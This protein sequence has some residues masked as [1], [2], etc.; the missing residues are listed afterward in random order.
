MGVYNDG[1]EL[2][3]PV[4]PIIPILLLNERR[5]SLECGQGGVL[6]YKVDPSSF[7]SNIKALK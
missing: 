1:G 2:W 7:P 3:A 4:E 6:Q 5:P